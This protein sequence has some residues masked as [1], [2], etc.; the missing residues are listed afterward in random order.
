MEAEADPFVK[1]LSL[2]HDKT[3]FPTTT[4]FQAFRGQ[5]GQCDVTVV[6][7]GKDHVYGKKIDLL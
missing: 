5:H 3:F 7:N 1:H 6:T 2:E 4:P